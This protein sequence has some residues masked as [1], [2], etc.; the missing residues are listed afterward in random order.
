MEAFMNYTLWRASCATHVKIALVAL[1]F[2]SVVVMVG[3]N[4]RSPDASSMHT[5]LDGPIKAQKSPSHARDDATRAV[6]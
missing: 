3:M 6:R 1:F 5:R 2:A 4:A